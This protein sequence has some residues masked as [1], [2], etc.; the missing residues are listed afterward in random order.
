MSRLAQV[1]FDESA[2]P[3]RRVRPDRHRSFGA[4][5]ARRQFCRS[6]DQRQNSPEGWWLPSKSAFGF[7]RQKRS[8]LFGGGKIFQPR[9]RR[10]SV[11]LDI[12]TPSERKRFVQRYL[13]RDSS[14]LVRMN[15]ATCNG[16]FFL[17]ECSLIQDGVFRP[18][19]DRSA[20]NYLT[21][22]DDRSRIPVKSRLRWLSTIHQISLRRS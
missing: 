12:I 17:I 21:S 16:I 4:V 2:C 14:W 3:T 13:R 20:S 8:S 5:P 7:C 10:P 11:L 15:L 9:Q 19:R 6:S 18:R 22:C 1:L